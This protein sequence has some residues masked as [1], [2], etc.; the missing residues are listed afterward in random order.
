M[1]HEKPAITSEMARGINF[2]NIFLKANTRI[3]M[4]IA[5]I[6]MSSISV[7]SDLIELT[8]NI[9]NITPAADAMR[10]AKYI[11]LELALEKSREII[12]AAKKK[13]ITTK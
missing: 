2:R 13:G 3:N 12:I 4:A 1:Y 6:N 9:G 10:F 8:V 7:F 5:G 11:L